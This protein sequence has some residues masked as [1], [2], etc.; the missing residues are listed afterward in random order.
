VALFSPDVMKN[1]LLFVFSFVAWSVSA[2]TR[3]DTV[4]CGTIIGYGKTVNGKKEGK[5]NYYDTVYKTP[6]FTGNY[7]HGEKTGEWIFIPHTYSAEKRVLHYKNNLL[8]GPVTIYSDNKISETGAYLDGFQH[9]EWIDYD[10]YGKRITSISYY[11]KGVPTGIWKMFPYEHFSMSGEMNA[12]GNTGYWIYTDSIYVTDMSAP[13]FNTLKLD[14][15]RIDSAYYVNGLAEGFWDNHFGKGNYVHGKKE[16]KWIEKYGDRMEILEYKNGEGHGYDSIFYKGVLDWVN[17][18]K[19]G[20]IDGLQSSFYDGILIEQGTCIPNPQ[21]KY[22]VYESH[23][24][25]IPI[26]LEIDLIENGAYNPWLMV[27]E[28][29]GVAGP[30]QRDSL[31]QAL[32]GR[33]Y[34]PEKVIIK[35]VFETQPTVRVGKWTYY[36]ENGKLKSEGVHLPIVKDSSAWDSTNQVEDPNNPG[37]FI[38]AP[39]K[40]DCS[41]YYKTGWWKYYNEQGVMIREERYGEAGELLEIK[42]AGQ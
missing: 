23:R 41:I 19:N 2:Q 7:L 21:Y 1:F 38:M 5:W 11:E 3:V 8:H 32:K 16:G 26:D 39:L 13:N 20:K 31:I 40:Y 12:Y 42:K 33:T 25:E 22:V 37:T 34:T 27:I 17:Y 36:W 30:H 35:S 9:G 14:K 15:V 4:R 29:H 28:N 24:V 18:Y 6:S 10:Y